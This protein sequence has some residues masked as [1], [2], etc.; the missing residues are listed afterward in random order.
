MFDLIESAVR[1]RQ[2]IYPPEQSG[3]GTNTFTV[4]GCK[5]VGH[6]P[7]YCV[8][9]NKLKAFERDKALNS[10]PECERAIS[11]RSCPAIGMRE[12]ERNA[13]KAL[14]FIDRTLLREEME[15]AFASSAASFRTTKTSAPAPKSEPTKTTAKKVA[16]HL[17]TMP[18]PEIDGYAAAINAAIKEASSAS[19]E[20]TPE[21][22]VASPSP[23][24][25]NKGLSMIERTRL[26]MGLNKE[27]P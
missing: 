1:D 17:T 6:T 21:P 12:E 8:C 5:A 16:D 15:K 26:Q 9:L 10:Y 18:T 3:A 7:G 19:P 22:K 11:G 24:P 20:P 27:T 25:V 14:Y 23:S 4:K 13:G 2:P